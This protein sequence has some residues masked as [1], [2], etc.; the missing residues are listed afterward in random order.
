VGTF[1]ISVMVSVLLIAVMLFGIAFQ[2][3]KVNEQLRRILDYLKSG[4]TPFRT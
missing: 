1:E 3:R 4:K 2:L